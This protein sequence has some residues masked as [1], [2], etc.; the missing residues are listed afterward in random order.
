MRPVDI[1][2]FYLLEGASWVEY[3]DGI[4]SVDIQRG[5]QKYTSPMDMP[6]A[7]IMRLISRSY[8]VDPYEN[9]NFRTGRTVKVEA[10]GTPIFTGRLID[11]N[12]SYNPKG[13]PPQIELIAIDM[14]GTMQAH[15]LQDSF[16]DRLGGAMTI[17]MFLQEMNFTSNPGADAEI[18]DFVSAQAPSDIGVAGGTADALYYPPLGTS[19]WGFYTQLAK[20]NLAFLYANVDNEMVGVDD[21]AVLGAA[22]PRNNPS[23]ATFDSTG[24]QLGY[25]NVVL[26]DGFDILC[27][28]FKTTNIGQDFGVASN[29]ASATNWGPGFKQLDTTLFIGP[30]PSQP[31]MTNIIN[32]VFSET[33]FPA[34]DISSIS[35][36]GKFDPDLAKTI[37]IYDNIDIYHEVDV[38]TIDKKYQIVGIQ[39]RIDAENW[40]ITY[41]LKNAFLD[42]EVLGYP[43]IVVTPSTGGTNT[44]FSF[45]IDCDRP[46]NIV[47]VNWDWGD[48]TPDSTGLTATHS[49]ATQATYT[50]TATITDI[51][52]IPRVITKQQ[53]VSGALP[54]SNFT[55]AVN[56]S[57]SGLIEFTYT[58]L[59]IPDGPYNEYVWDFGDGSTGQNRFKPIVGNL[60]TTAGNKTVSLTT[61]NQYGS[62]TTTQVIPV[63]PG[64][65]T[66]TVGNRAVRYIRILMDPGS[67]KT[68]PIN[69]F[70]LMSKLKALTSNGTNRALNKPISFAE[71]VGV[72]GYRDSA[73]NVVWP[74]GNTPNT[75][76]LA[77]TD[78]STT[79]YGLKPVG[80]DSSN[81]YR[82]FG[83]TIDLGQPYYDL[84]QF[85]I[86]LEQTVADSDYSPMAIQYQTDA[87]SYFNQTVPYSQQGGWTT[88]NAV[89]TVVTTVLGTDR[90][91]T[92][93]PTLPL[94]W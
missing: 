13:K 76:P 58:G 39:H 48:S 79:N 30:P 57:N 40:N 45:S 38:L 46:E 94:N 71:Q 56:P 42:Q 21:W 90:T 17:S 67:A 74:I 92:N 7:G 24:G 28:R 3:T 89:G 82:M 22:H 91:F 59:P 1:I 25:F 62:S 53:Y 9:S 43:T 60:Y 29:T 32:R 19:A 85:Q 66:S 12:V 69:F 68:A 63:T 83:I 49:F 16:R 14:V 2:K 37:E 11:I 88:P 75:K 87:S 27:N 35:W 26:N 10:N 44:V 86:T 84:S 33:V 47:S 80:F 55:W 4:I 23:V 18:I 51:Y 81:A 72:N 54:T 15:V 52:N 31:G 93:I 70:P 73:G 34:R 61:T 5:L 8:S 6:D 50:I 41:S 36:N 78:T 77:L 64:T 20:S 65:V